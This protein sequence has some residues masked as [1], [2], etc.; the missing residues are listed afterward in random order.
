M[1]LRHSTPSTLHP[2]TMGF[3]TE[4]F[5][6]PPSRSLLCSICHDVLEKALTLRCGHSFCAGCLDQQQ[7]AAASRRL[8]ARRNAAET[9]RPGRRLSAQAPNANESEPAPPQPCATCR[10]DGG[11]AIPNLVVRDMVGALRVSCRNNIEGTSSSNNDSSS[12]TGTSSSSNE[13][14]GR[15]VR[16]RLPNGND[17][18]AAAAAA[19]AETEAEAETETEKCDWT[20]RLDEWT[21]HAQHDCGLTNVHCDIAGCDTVCLRRHLANHQRTS[22][23]CFNARIDG[24]VSA[25]VTELETKFANKLNDIERHHAEEM[26]SLRAKVDRGR[27]GGHLVQFYREWLIRKPDPVFDFVVYRQ[28]DGDGGVPGFDDR[29]SVM[30]GETGPT[31]AALL[32]GIPGPDWTPWA[33]GLYPALVLWK[34]DDWTKPPLCKFPHGFHHPNVYPSGTISLSTIVEEER[35]RPDITLPEI[36][37]DIQQL[38]A[39][40]NIRSP[41][42]SKA[43]HSFV[44][45]KDEY[46]R[47]ATEHANKYR[48]DKLLELATEAF[49]KVII[50]GGTARDAPVERIPSILV[51]DARSHPPTTRERPIPPPPPPEGHTDPNH[52]RPCSCSCCA[53]LKASG[54]GLWDK[55]FRMRFI[56]GVGG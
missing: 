16:R 6:L 5:L 23:S 35:W 31:T 18:T 3:P 51:E 44:K 20:G 28:E 17:A 49:T 8:V 7:H 52:G 27:N 42:Q 13:S 36:M 50:D 39:H 24:R 56:W 30:R 46:D 34:N 55:S 47:I 25:A 48:P 37:F 22:S 9:A 43:Y 32:V 26:D 14:E 45:D 4:C 19:A 41:S 12:N 11:G 40:P 15:R 53:W 10:G 1:T 38:L 33:G 21:R 54:G 2:T 29:F